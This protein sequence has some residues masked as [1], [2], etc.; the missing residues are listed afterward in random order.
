MRKH[1]CRIYKAICRRIGPRK[2]TISAW[3]WIREQEGHGWLLRQIVDDWFLIYRIE[4]EHCKKSY[5][6]ETA[7]K[8]R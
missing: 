3:L 2:M 6:R 7:F 4:D 5:E 8:P 1:V